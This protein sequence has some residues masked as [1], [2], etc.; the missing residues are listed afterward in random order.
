VISRLPLINGSSDL[1][2]LFLSSWALQNKSIKNYEFAL[3]AVVLISIV[4]TLPFYIYFITYFGIVFL[5]NILKKRV[6]QTPILA[7]A[8]TIIIGTLLEHGLTIIWLR[9]GGNI[10]P[11][12]Q[13]IGLVTVPT[14]LL[15]LILSIPVYAIISNISGSLFPS[16]SES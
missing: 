7:L 11:I 9:L 15:N 8:F 4:S 13:T 3:I 16:E 1:F 6:W 12:I 14:L 5:A 2:I 10:L